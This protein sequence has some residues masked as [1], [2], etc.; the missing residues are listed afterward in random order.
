MQKQLFNYSF[1][2]TEYK[3][4]NIWQSQEIYTKFAKETIMLLK[5]VLYNNRI[6]EF[7]EKYLSLES[8]LDG[9]IPLNT[10]AI[11]RELG[12]ACQK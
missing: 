1:A 12:V 9:Y 4:I 5:A 3:L 8:R 7:Y 2:N 6:F 11:L 10:E